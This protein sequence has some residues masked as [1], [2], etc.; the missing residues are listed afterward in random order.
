MRIWEK[1]RLFFG[2]LLGDR[3][4]AGPAHV[5]LDVT[6]RCNL[7]CPGCPF[8]HSVY[9][10]S[11][12]GDAAVQDI[13]M[14]LVEK[15]AAEIP[16]LGVRQV[17]IAGDGEP[18][19]HPHLPLIIRALKQS[20]CLVQVFTNGLLLTTAMQ[21][22]LID[23]GLDRL[24]VSLWAGTPQEYEQCYE[25]LPPKNFDRVTANIQSMNDLKS[26]K[27]SILPGIT[28]TGPVTQFTA[29]HLENRMHLAKRLGCQ[30]VSYTV[31]RE[32]GFESLAGTALTLPQMQQ[33][34]KDVPRLKKTA[35][36]LG[37]RHNL[38]ELALR[39]R[40]GAQI[41]KNSPCSAGWYHANIHVDGLVTPCAQ[42]PAIWG[43]MNQN[44]LEEIWNDKDI[45]RFRRLGRSP[46]AWIGM[47]PV[48]DCD[49]CCFTRDNF[50][51]HRVM[52]WFGTA[53]KKR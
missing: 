7:R 24:Y 18:L 44:S 29:P 5:N 46:G 4:Y 12:P 14:E 17:M 1:S 45:R 38:D 48:C 33:F 2:L 51:V 13:S 23:S 25:G 35:Q 16:R 21:Q 20:G 50:R 6:R 9:P 15:L 11:I 26:Q 36:N 39:Y 19:L 53:R 8:H 52:R 42:C 10:G 28:L 41:W 22:M 30:A 3:N 31:Y 40:L 27:K 47:A 49:W 43:N 37:I 34:I 32:R